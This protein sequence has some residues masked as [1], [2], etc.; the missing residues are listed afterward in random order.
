M[1]CMNVW[2]SSKSGHLAALERL[3]KFHKRIIGKM[4]LHFVLVVFGPVILILADTCNKSIHKILD[5]YE[6]RPAPTNDYRFSCRRASKNRMSPLSRL[7]L[8]RTYLNL[9][10]T[11]KCIISWMRSN[12]GQ[13]GPRSKLPLGVKNRLRM[14]KRMS[15]LFLGWFLPAVV[16]K[17]MSPLHYFII[18]IQSM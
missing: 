9:K 10:I 2:M 6:F 14:W 5:T 7:L 13:F 16:F 8:I 11:R 18:V 17:A 4:G 12:F 3:K 15:R 1:T